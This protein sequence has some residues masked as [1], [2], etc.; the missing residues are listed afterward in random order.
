MLARELA[1][2]K[3]MQ[4]VGVLGIGVMLQTS[5]ITK[6]IKAHGTLNF[7]QMNMHVLH[8]KHPP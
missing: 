6:A 2:R 1:V 5:F 7:T 4:L 3:V 8:K